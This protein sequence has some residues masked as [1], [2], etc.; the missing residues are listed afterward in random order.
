MKQIGEQIKALRKNRNMTQEQLAAQLGVSAQSVSKWENHLTAPDI[1]L[2]PVLATV[3][4]VSLDELFDYNRQER[5]QA[6]AAVCRAAWEC[7]GDS[8]NSRMRMREMLDEGLRRFPGHPQ[9]LSSYLYTLD[10]ETEND[11]IIRLATEL[12][13]SVEG[14]RRY[15]EVRFDALQ[16]LAK[17]Y[18]RAGEPAFARATVERIPEFHF[19]RMSVAAQVLTGPEKRDA[20]CAQKWESVEMLVDMMR[21]LASYYLAEGQSGSA[22]SEKEKARQL[23][24]LFADE[25]HKWVEELLIEV[26]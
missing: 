17:A 15:D 20:A 25:D 6:V 22:R 21:E 16:A 10:Y 4:E 5:D 26:E 3:F 7:R 9:L 13:E 19:T 2:L 18:A 14:D 11:E 24:R 23:I 8:Q 1:S 12:I